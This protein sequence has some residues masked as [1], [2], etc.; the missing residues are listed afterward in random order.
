MPL[1][2]HIFLGI[3]GNL[4]PQ[5]LLWGVQTFPDSSPG[6]FPPSWMPQGACKDKKT[7]VQGGLD[8][9]SPDYLRGGSG[10]PSVCLCPQLLPL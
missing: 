3:L 4:V 10:V 5:Y 8:S 7:P 1:R 6:A 9:L 2:T